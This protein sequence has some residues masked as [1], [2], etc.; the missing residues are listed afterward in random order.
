MTQIPLRN[1]NGCCRIKC[2]SR[3]RACYAC[4]SAGGKVELATDPETGLC[5]FHTEHGAEARRTR[6]GTLKELPS[7]CA[8]VSYTSAASSVCAAKAPA[9]PTLTLVAERSSEPRPEL[10]QPVRVPTG[11]AGSLKKREYIRAARKS[12]GV[13]VRDPENPGK[14]ITLAALDLL[15]RMLVMRDTEHKDTN[16]IAKHFGISSLYTYLILRLERL[17]PEVQKLLMPDAPSTL[18]LGFAF[19]LAMLKPEFQA[20]TAEKIVRGSFSL[21]QLK[22]MAKSPDMR[23]PTKRARLAKEAT[24]EKRSMQQP[25]KRPIKRQLRAMEKATRA[26]MDSADALA[27]A[28]ASVREASPS[29]EVRSGVLARNAALRKRIARLLVEIEDPTEA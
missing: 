17:V 3:L 5:N 12:A 27:Q 20:S 8:R 23:A 10:P 24:H 15:S 16:A 21:K 6:Q 26:I 13:H 4:V 14:K 22:E 28:Y 11:V 25:T 29:D 19:E 7:I 2:A 9:A 18:P 1:R